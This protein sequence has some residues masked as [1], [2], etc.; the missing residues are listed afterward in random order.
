M[1]LAEIEG[2]HPAHLNPQVLQQKCYFSCLCFTQIDFFRVAWQCLGNM[3]Q[4][5]AMLAFINR[6]EEL[7]PLFDSYVEANKR[8]L[9]EKDRRL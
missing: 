2:T 1:S 6:L 4:G 3:S 9:E 7:C 8:D 5:D